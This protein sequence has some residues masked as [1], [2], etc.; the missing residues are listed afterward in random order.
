MSP[1]GARQSTRGDTLRARARVL[2]AI[3][4]HLDSLIFCEIEAPVAVASPGLEPQL[5][6]FELAHPEGPRR[7]LH[8]SPEYAL[9]RLLG[10]TDLRRIYSMGPCFRDEPTSRTHGP[11]FTMLE[12]YSDAVDLFGLMDQ[13]EALVRAAAV[14]AWGSPRAGDGTDLSPPFARQTVRAAF[15]EH[16]GVDPWLHASAEALRTAL[17]AAGVSIHTDSPDWDDVFFQAFLNVVEPALHRAGPTFLWGFPASQ[18]ALSRL[19]PN[20]PTRALRFELYAGGQE[21]A[22]AFDELTDPAEQRQRFEADLALRAELGRQVPPIDERLLA[23]L[24]GMVPTCGIALGVDRLVMWLLGID[25]LAA[26]RAQP[27][28]EP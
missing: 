10:T 16:T 13:C 21:L 17:R 25:D 24:P 15:T 1:S 19:D 5:D 3:R 2:R 9:K 23:A 22:N 4:N 7:Y 8:T 28:E 12:W 20:D 11:E 26:V 6:A 27:W 18:A 14:G